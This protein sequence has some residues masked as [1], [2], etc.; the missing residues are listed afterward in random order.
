MNVVRLQLNS[1]VSTFCLLCII[2]SVLCSLLQ[3]PNIITR[4]LIIDWQRRQWFAQNIFF[5]SIFL[6]QEFYASI[7]TSFHSSCVV[8]FQKKKKLAKFIVLVIFSL[9]FT[10]FFCFAPLPMHSSF[11]ARS[12]AVCRVTSLKLFCLW[13]CSLGR[14]LINT[15]TCF[16]IIFFQFFSGRDTA[17]GQTRCKGY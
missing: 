6:L 2:S 15:H 5:S 1:K 7:F 4:P 13:L 16:I 9:L 10:Y 17:D 11:A 12:T 14:V 8:V 3:N